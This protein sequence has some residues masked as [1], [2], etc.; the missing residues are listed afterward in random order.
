MNKLKSNSVKAKWPKM[1]FL[2]ILPKR[3][4]RS[5]IYYCIQRLQTE[6]WLLTFAEKWLRMLWFLRRGQLPILLQAESH[7]QIC[8][9]RNGFIL[10]FKVNL[11]YFLTFIYTLLQ[12]LMFILTTTFVKWGQSV[13]KNACFWQFFSTVGSVWCHR[14]RMTIYTHLRH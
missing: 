5:K 8:F 7:K 4:D 11:L 9:T 12:Q 2:I 10:R 13:C 6:W 14:E 3:N 1:S